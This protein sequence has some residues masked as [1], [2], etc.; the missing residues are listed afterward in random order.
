ETNPTAVPAIG[1]DRVPD[2][3]HPRRHGATRYA[4]PNFRRAIA[5]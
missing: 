1:N 3:R 5:M 2:Q 4:R